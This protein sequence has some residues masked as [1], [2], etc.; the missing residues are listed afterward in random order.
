MLQVIDLKIDGEFGEVRR[1]ARHADIIDVAI[2]LGDYG[3]NL[4][5]ASGLVDIVDKN[6]RRAALGRRLVD[7][8]ADVE[9]ALRLLLEFLECGRLDRIDR[10]A[11][12][13]GYDA[14]NAV[15]RH[16]TAIRREFDRQIRIDA[17][18][19]YGGHVSCPC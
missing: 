6:S 12:P 3:G 7:A 8:P 4:G 17:A 15:A 2:M 1:A 11:L 13:R 19:R 14:D 9:P 10:D 16:R 18:D 5:E